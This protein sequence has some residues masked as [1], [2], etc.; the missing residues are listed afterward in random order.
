MF[1]SQQQRPLKSITFS[2][3]EHVKLVQIAAFMLRGAFSG[4]TIYT[5]FLP[6]LNVERELQRLHQIN[7]HQTGFRTQLINT[8][9]FCFL[10]TEPRTRV[11][12]GW[13]PILSHC[14]GETRRTGRVSSHRHVHNTVQR[15]SERGPTSNLRE[16]GGDQD[17]RL[18]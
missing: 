8:V 12:Q 9:N 13:Y 15:G 5:L 2:H 10:S 14:P 17:H 16:L 11:L 4:E 18:R 1:V 7:E 3:T 6:L